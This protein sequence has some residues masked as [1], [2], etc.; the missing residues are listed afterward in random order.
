MTI[1]WHINLPIDEIANSWLLS[2][3]QFYI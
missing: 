2:F 3:C 1:Q